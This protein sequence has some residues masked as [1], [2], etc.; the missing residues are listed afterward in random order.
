MPAIA[1]NGYIYGGVPESSQSA[2]DVTYNNAATQL[3]ATTVQDA[4][5]ESY[6]AF[7]ALGI[8]V[9]NGEV[10]QTVIEED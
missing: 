7:S 1:R 2:D 5:D 10:V 3:T 6:T 8:S 9:V 4:I